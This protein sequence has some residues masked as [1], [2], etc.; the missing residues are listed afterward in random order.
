MDKRMVSFFNSRIYVVFSIHTSQ[1]TLKIKMYMPCIFNMFEKDNYL[2][3]FYEDIYK[4]I[5]KIE[6]PEANKKVRI[7]SH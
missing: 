7:N 5:L 1:R 3:N 6:I 4:L 2:T